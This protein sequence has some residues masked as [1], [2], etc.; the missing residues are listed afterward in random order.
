MICKVFS[1]MMMHIL[2]HMCLP[3]WMLNFISKLLNFFHIIHVCILE[4]QFKKF[5]FVLSICVSLIHYELFYV[6][7]LQVKGT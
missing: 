2:T 6:H 1:S 4:I 5:P 3:N 7:C